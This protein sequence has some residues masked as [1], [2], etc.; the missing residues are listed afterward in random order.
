MNTLS[1]DAQ[2]KYVDVGETRVVTNSKCIAEQLKS[3]RVEKVVMDGST[4]VEDDGMDGQRI[5]KFGK[6]L[7]NVVMDGKKVGRFGKVGAEENLTKIVTVGVR[8]EEK[9]C[10]SIMNGF[11][12]R[13][14]ETCDVGRDGRRTS[15]RCM[16]RRHHWKRIEILA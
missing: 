9:L 15:G 3:D 4:L 6:V 11:A 5:G 8:T 16:R 10:K 7:E 12:R 2:L 1:H 13:N 14:R